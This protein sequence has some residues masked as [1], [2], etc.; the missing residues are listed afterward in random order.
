MADKDEFKKYQ[1]MMALKRQKKTEKSKL[2]KGKGR[3]LPAKLSIQ[4]LSAQ[5]KGSSQKYARMGPLKRV[6]VLEDD[7]CQTPHIDMVRR[8]CI[9]GFNIKGFNCDLLESERGPSIENIDEIK[10]LNGTIFVR[11]TQKLSSEFSEFELVD[12][13]DEASETSGNI[14][15]S[16]LN[17]LR[18]VL[19]V[20]KKYV[21]PPW[22]KNRKSLSLR[23]CQWQ[24]C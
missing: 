17:I 4:R 22:R 13:D 19:L 1:A 18:K 5:V 8:A 20:D 6:D 24:Q 2:T 16:Q 14:T 21:P 9:A 23:P 7:L 15:P 10:N 12:S 3:L 11:F